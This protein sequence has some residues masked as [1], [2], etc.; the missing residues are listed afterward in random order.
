MRK[1]K[2]FQRYEKT[3][4][5]CTPYRYLIYVYGH[6]QSVVLMFL[7]RDCHKWVHYSGSFGFS[8]ADSMNSVLY[9]TSR[10]NVFSLFLFASSEYKWVCIHCHS[11]DNAW[12]PCTMR[13]WLFEQQQ[14]D[15]DGVMC[16]RLLG[17]IVCNI[18]HD[19]VGAR[20]RCHI[21]NFSQI[22][23][24]R[25][26]QKRHCS[27]TSPECFE[28][29]G[30]PDFPLCGQCIRYARQGPIEIWKWT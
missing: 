21:V 5:G 10:L 28:G 23:S 1:V 2:S 7:T 20:F 11:G 9:M 13:N 12:D 14:E 29:G 24:S 19:K 8:I 4:G 18:F 30:M 27:T 6:W 16:D 15:R 17:L 25:K 3:S 22:I 26:G